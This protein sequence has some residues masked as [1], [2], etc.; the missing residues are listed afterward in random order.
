MFFQY[1]YLVLNLINKQNDIDYLTITQ[2]S[3]IKYMSL[4]QKVPL[5]LQLPLLK[6][7]TILYNYDRMSLLWI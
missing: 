6:S 2:V 7:F 4:Q 3:N 1:H 5:E